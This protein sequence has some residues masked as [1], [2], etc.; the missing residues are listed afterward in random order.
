MPLSLRDIEYFAVVAEHGNIGRAAE[1]LG[2]SQ[3]ALSM[4]LRRLEKSLQAKLV[5]RTPK[6]VELTAVGTALLGHVRRLRLSLEDVE[7]EA[8]DLSQGSAGD[9]RIGA[10]PGFAEYLLP[11]ACSALFKTTPKVTLDVTVEDLG[12]LLPPLRSGELDLIVSGISQSPH[13]GLAQEHLLDDKFVVVSSVEQRLARKK[14]VTIAD[15]ADE[16]WAMVATNIMPGQWLLKAFEEH[17]LPR[18][19][20]TMVSNSAWLRLCTVACSNL[21]NLS[22]LRFVRQTALRSRLA[23]L[24][25]KELTWTRRVGVIYRKDGYLSPAARQFIEILKTTAREI[26]REQA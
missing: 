12:K 22:S 6:G 18:P 3:P 4:S 13:E 19:R 9:L 21:L 7:R 14:R 25:I 23:I 2:L 16:H 11:T 17:G 26:T 20:I 15:V 24:P 1:A 5:K 8:A 10:S